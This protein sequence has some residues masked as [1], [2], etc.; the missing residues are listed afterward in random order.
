MIVTDQPIM[1]DGLRLRIELERDLRVV[2]EAS[3][4]TAAA[5]DVLSCRP[6]VVVIDL[7]L[8]KGEGLR[9]INTL[10]ALAP[11][12]PMVV[13]ADYPIDLAAKLFA[14]GTPLI[15]VSKIVTGAEVIRAI[16]QALLRTQS[17]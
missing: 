5:R 14:R 7:Q 3:D 1:R 12:L 13:L 11:H 9:A 8:P 6:D 15:M 4:L 10:D 17:E 16:R 2:C